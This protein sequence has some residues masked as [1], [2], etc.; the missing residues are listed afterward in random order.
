MGWDWNITEINESKQ[1]TCP[2]PVFNH[3]QI[4][5]ATQHSKKLMNIHFT[6]DAP[7][8]FIHKSSSHLTRL[9]QCHRSFPGSFP[10]VKPTGGDFRRSN[11]PM[12]VFNFEFG[13]DETTGSRGDDCEDSESSNRPKKTCLEVMCFQSQTM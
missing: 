2:F 10:K 5:S 3:P 4:L 6:S 12:A 11:S 7:F 13:E 9:I 1:Q 8:G